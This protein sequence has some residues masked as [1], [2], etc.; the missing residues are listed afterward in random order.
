M[1]GE[2]EENLDS[3]LRADGG[4]KGAGESCDPW[5]NSLRIRSTLPGGPIWTG[6][7]LLQGPIYF[8]TG[9]FSGDYGT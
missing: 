6:D 8:V 1:D 2:P 7:H 3:S 5:G 4:F 9:P